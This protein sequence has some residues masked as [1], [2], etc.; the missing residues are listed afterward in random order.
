[1]VEELLTLR[2]TGSR[3]Q[4]HVDRQKLPGIEASTGCLGQGIGMAVGMAL[5]NR[6]AHR[7]SRVYTILGDGECQAGPTWEALMAG[8]HYKLDN[9]V[10]L[11]DRNGYETDGS[12]ESIMGIDPIVDKFRA[13]RYETIEIDGHD[14]GQ[15][16][17]A[18]ARAREHH[19]GPTAIVAN[20]VK[21]KG[22]SFMEHQHA[23]HGKAP[24]REEAQKALVELGATL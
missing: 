10:V 21:G 11:L 20:T 7:T 22:V 5:D 3:L 15:I 4:G 24:S 18:F 6:L 23:W 8:G 2:K 1:P 14:F 12:T 9:L 16:L 19:G 13:F 17:D